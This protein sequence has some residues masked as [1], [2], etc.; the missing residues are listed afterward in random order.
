M[1]LDFNEIERNVYEIVKARFISRINRF[2]KAGDL[3]RQYGYV[4]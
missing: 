3:D 4:W 1:W 2:S